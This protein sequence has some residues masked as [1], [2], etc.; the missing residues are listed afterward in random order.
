MD[1]EQLK[2]FEFLRHLDDQQLI[3]LVNNS[4]TIR[5]LPGEQ[6]ITAGESD[7]FEF[8]LLAGELASACCAIRRMRSWNRSYCSCCSRSCSSCSRESEPGRRVS[9]SSRMSL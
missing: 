2:Q 9:W 8:F 1:I 6:I 5:V 3:M 4:E 7:G